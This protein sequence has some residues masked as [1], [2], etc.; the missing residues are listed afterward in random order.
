[1]SYNCQE[2]KGLTLEELGFLSAV[3]LDYR[4]GNVQTH[5]PMGEDGPAHFQPTTAAGELIAGE[6]NNDIDAAG[7]PYNPMFHSDAKTKTDKGLWRARRN[8]TAE[9]KAAAEQFAASF[10]AP[11]Y[12][13]QQPAGNQWPLQQPAPEAYHQPAPPPP[14]QPQAGP[15]PVDYG[16]WYKLW[17]SLHQDGRGHLNNDL[18]AEMNHTAGVPNTAQYVHNDGAR[19]ISYDYMVRLANHYGL[20]IAA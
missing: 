8:M 2:I 5:V 3:L 18:V 4:A 6:I 9:Q 15:R 12:Q 7:V 19:A 13:P 14:H 17:A 20:A 11:A 10:K 16:T 1:M